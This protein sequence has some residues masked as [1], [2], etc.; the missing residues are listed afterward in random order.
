MNGGARIR[1]VLFVDHETR[2][3]G[4]QRDLVDLVRGLRELDRASD[5][6][7][8]VALPGAG[9]LADRLTAE[10]ATVH[11]VAMAERLRAVSRWELASRPTSVA[12]LSSETARAVAAL[13]RL[14]ERVQPDVVH[15]NTMK[16]HVLATPAAL[17]HRVPLVWH[18][19]DVLEP[20]WVSRAFNATAGAAAWRVVCISQAVAAAFSGR[21]RAKTRVVYNGIRPAPV[22]AADVAA[23]RARLGGATGNPVVGIVGQIA[24]WKGQDV[25]LDAAARLADA[26][27]DLRFAVVGECLFP[28]NEGEFDG[29]VRA[30]AASGALASRVVFTGAV[31]P[32]EPVMAALDLVVHASRLPEPFGRVIV[33]AMAQGTAVVSTTAGAGPELVPDDAGAV[34]APGDPAALAHAIDRLTVDG[35][36][37]EA[38][39]APARRAAARFD[40]SATARGVLAVYDELGRR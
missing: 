8:H 29:A 28:D 36:A 14:V 38:M 33:E 20:S 39:A 27:P 30:T 15:T 13:T 1:R 7:L 16:A 19:R 2:L 18:I 35:A 9:P 3:S 26:R 22:A 23:A 31:E 5:L 24:R 4:G 6:D 32:I 11:V 17:R 25:F 10:G 21:A 40:I 37:L 12:R 34:V